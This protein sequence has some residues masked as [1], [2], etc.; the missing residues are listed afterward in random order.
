[1]TWSLE[2]GSHGDAPRLDIDWREYGLVVPA[3]ESGPPPRG[4]G[5]ELIERALPYQ[6]NATTGLSC[7]RTV[8]TAP[9]PSP[10]RQARPP[11]TPRMSDRP[12]DGCHIL[13]VED[14]YL[15]A[16]E[17]QMA[18]EDAGAVVIGPAA[19]L[20]GAIGL[21]RSGR[22]ID[23]A[24]LDV[25]LGGEMVFPAADLLI[26]RG[27]P[28]ILST[29]YDASIIPERLRTAARC[30]KPINIRRIIEAITARCAPEFRRIVEDD[31]G[32]R[33]A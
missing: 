11:R 8:F 15:L 18:L 19:D 9:F 17:L 22:P 29:G 3:G 24:I 10:F 28:I 4:Q 25:N 32:E 13:L 21:A 6:L 33:I 20:A 27:V 14:E 12:L 26:E 31:T 7:G 5:R 16:D 2:Q 23:G 30:E 1:M